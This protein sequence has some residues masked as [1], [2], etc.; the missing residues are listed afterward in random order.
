MYIRDI[1]Q[2]DG[3]RKSWGWYLVYGIFLVIGGFFMAGAP[4]VTTLASA[5]F[6]GVM[7]LILGVIHAGNAIIARDKGWGW[8]LLGGIISALAGLILM[9]D[10]VSGAIGLTF[11]VSVFL[12]MSGMFKILLSLKW[13]PHHGWGVLLFNGIVAV[14]LGWL[15]YA[16]W[17]LSGL[18]IIGFYLGIE[19]LFAGFAFISLAFRVKA[20]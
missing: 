7:L 11:L 20:S 9:G 15:V 12:I 1:M 18:W 5:I 13:R 8:A 17:P 10:P 3:P 6:F 14:V 4:A 2:D 19:A 16:Q